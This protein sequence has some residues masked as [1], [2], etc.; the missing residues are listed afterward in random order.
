M[1]RTLTSIQNKKYSSFLQKCCG[2]NDDN[3]ETAA[4]IEA[5]NVKLRP[6]SRFIKRTQLKELKISFNQINSSL[7]D[8]KPVK[9]VKESDHRISRLLWS[10]VIV[11]IVS[12]S[13]FFLVKYSIDWATSSKTEI[14]KQKDQRLRDIAE[15]LTVKTSRLDN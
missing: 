7:T 10:L 3:P 9:N 11:L 12:L 2:D 8:N 6:K 15:F 4:A 13:I 1:N 5:M 14:N